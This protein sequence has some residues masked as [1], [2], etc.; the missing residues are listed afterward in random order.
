[1]GQGR[2]GWGGAGEASL[3]RKCSGHSPPGPPLPLPWA[4]QL[5]NV[6]LL[7]YRPDGEAQSVLGCSGLPCE[8]LAKREIKNFLRGVSASSLLGNCSL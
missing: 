7:T 3:C 2:E 8:L 5:L 4:W 1:M 6:N